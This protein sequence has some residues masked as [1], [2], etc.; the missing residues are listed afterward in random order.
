MI[1]PLG[2]GLMFPNLLASRTPGQGARGW[3]GRKRLEPPVG[4]P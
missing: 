2:W 4:A 3:G 1:G